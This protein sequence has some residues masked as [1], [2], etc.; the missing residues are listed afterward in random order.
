[1]LHFIVNIRGGSGKAFLKWNKIQKIL[2][3]KNI[4]YKTH[5]TQRAGH[6]SQIARELSLSDESDLRLVV[7]GGDGALNEVING[8]G[9]NTRKAKFRRKISRKSKSGWFRQEAETILAGE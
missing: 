1:M 2:K 4:E 9:K 5:V 7:V 3:D 6:A 8:I